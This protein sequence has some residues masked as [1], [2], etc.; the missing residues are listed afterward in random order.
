[1]GKPTV[2]EGVEVRAG[3]VGVGVRLNGAQAHS[4][5]PSKNSDRCRNARRILSGMAA[6]GAF[7][8]PT[9]EGSVARRPEWASRGE[10]PECEIVEI[11]REVSG[12]N[13]AGK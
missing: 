4:E 7:T 8:D 3:R 11:H 6:G 9:L 5:E 10:A 13:R 1:M 12:L 2:G